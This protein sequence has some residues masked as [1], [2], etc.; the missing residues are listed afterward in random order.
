[1]VSH[2]PFIRRGWVSPGTPS[3]AD[4]VFRSVCPNRVSWPHPAAGEAGRAGNRV[5]RTGSPGRRPAPWQSQRKR[6]DHSGCLLAQHVGGAQS[7]QWTATHAGH[8]RGGRGRCRPPGPRK[9]Q[10]LPLVDLGPLTARSQP[11][12][13]LWVQCPQTFAW[14]ELSP[15]LFPV[16]VE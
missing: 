9:T 15:T 14:C 8:S 3:P 6:E 1:M 10:Q 16:G 5:V 12:G 13:T 4:F 11:P 2:S 7:R